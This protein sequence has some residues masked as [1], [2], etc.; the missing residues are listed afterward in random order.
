MEPELGLEIAIQRMV[1]WGLGCWGWVGATRTKP[2]A[3]SRPCSCSRTT[4]LVVA[5]GFL[6]GSFYG[7]LT[8]MVGSVLGAVFTFGL[9]RRLFRNWVESRVRSSLLLR[10][11][12]NAVELHAFKMCALVGQMASGRG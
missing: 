4:P 6:Y 5:A 9:C 7:F 11:V 2:V 3:D 8:S 1:G 10:A 12:R